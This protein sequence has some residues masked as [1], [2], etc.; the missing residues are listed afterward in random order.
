MNIVW[1]LVVGVAAGWFAGRVTNGRG[2]GLVGNMLIG[3]VGAVIGGYLFG[4]FGLSAGGGHLG[5]LV[6]AV[7]GAVLLLGVMRILKK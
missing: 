3:V 2:S 5:A 4:T 6:T 1:F 7:V